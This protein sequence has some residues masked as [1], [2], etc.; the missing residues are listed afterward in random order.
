M[1]NKTDKISTSNNAK[2]YCEHC[3]FDMTNAICITY[4]NGMITCD[5]CLNDMHITF[6]DRKE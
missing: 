4:V 6:N 1:V 5:K 2:T 3:G